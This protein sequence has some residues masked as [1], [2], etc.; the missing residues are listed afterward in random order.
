M[1]LR[2]VDCG[3]WWT[4][5]GRQVVELN[6][7]QRSN[8][9][10]DWQL[11]WFLFKLEGISWQKASQWLMNSPQAPLWVNQPRNVIQFG[12]EC[13]AWRFLLYQYASD[14]AL[15]PSNFIESSTSPFGILTFI[16]RLCVRL[17]IERRRA[18]LC[19]CLKWSNWK[20]FFLLFFFNNRFFIIGRKPQPN[21]TTE[22]TVAIRKRSIRDSFGSAGKIVMT[23][24]FQRGKQRRAHTANH[25]EN[26]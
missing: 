7:N 3:R 20:W 25:R 17:I 16:Q 23:N 5:S 6:A 24:A 1:R 4:T 8:R 12:G 22:V 11:R 14:D 18:H 10:K 2:R 26:V 19:W 21:A 9:P 13:S 15:F